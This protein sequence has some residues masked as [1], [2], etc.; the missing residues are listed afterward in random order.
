MLPKLQQS[1]IAQ[2]LRRDNPANH[3]Y[4][5]YSFIQVRIN[6]KISQ[7]I[8]PMKIINP[9]KP[10]SHPKIHIRLLE[11]SLKIISPK[12]K[13]KTKPLRLTMKIPFQ[14]LLA[15]TKE[16]EELEEK[17]HPPQKRKRALM[18]LFQSVEPSKKGIFHSPNLEDI[19]I[20]EIYQSV[21][22]IKAPLQNYYGKFQQKP[23]TIITICLYSLMEFVKKQTLTDHFLRWV[24][25]ISQIK[26]EVKFFQSSHNSLSLLK[27]TNI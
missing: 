16:K 18:H 8:L 6:L 22:I 7:A 17:L 3:N 15:K 11:T 25:T 27:V 19:T 4:C 5:N 21:S 9:G 2:S 24:H 23:Q 10:N 26:V 1:S 13:Q 14:D 12:L 20:E